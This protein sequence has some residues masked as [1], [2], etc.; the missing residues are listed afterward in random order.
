MRLP[1]FFTLPQRIQLDQLYKHGVYVG[2]RKRNGQSVLLFQ[3]QS[4]YAE[5]FYTTYR[6][7]IDRIVV[8]DHITVL[9]P[10]LDQIHIKFL[11]KKSC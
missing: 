6:K 5:I 8:T 7:E 1:D 10:Y 4:F 3:Y 9:D 11:N 2:K